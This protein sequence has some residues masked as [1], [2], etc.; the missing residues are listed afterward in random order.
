MFVGHSRPAGGTW[1][2]SGTGAAIVAGIDGIDDGRPDTVTA[3][4]WITGTQ[5]TSSV[6]RLR[7]DWTSGAIVPRLIGLSNLSLPPGTKVTAS[8]RRAGDTAGTYPYTPTAYNA[9][10]RVVE[11]PSGERTAWI[12]YP[13]GATPVIGCE[14]QI[15]ND[16]NGVASIPA[17]MQ[18][19]DGE[20]WV[21][22]GTDVPIATT[23]QDQPIDPTMTNWS[24][25][26]QPYTNP[27]TP[28]RQF[29][30]ALAT[31]NAEVWRNAYKPLLAKI[32]RGQRCF[33]CVSIYD[34]PGSPFSAD[35][36]H[37]DGLIGVCTTQPARKHNQ[38][39]IWDSGTCSVTESPIPT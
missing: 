5:N 14:W 38:N 35:A 26:N 11:G 12:M 7:Y 6:F 10:Q 3:L 33:Y 28:Y 27:G 21:S 4:K 37:A 23:P 30:F 1:S 31:A 17:G 9:T 2:V 22:A 36:L 18:F 34:R 19:Y 24:P 20:A 16:V 8:F 29:Q 39:G 13:G 25:T 32:N 15:W